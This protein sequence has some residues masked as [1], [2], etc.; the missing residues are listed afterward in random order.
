MFAFEQYLMHKL[1]HYRFTGLSV[2][3]ENLDPA[4]SWKLLI[5]LIAGMMAIMHITSIIF[6][7][8]KPGFYG[9][10]LTKNMVNLILICLLICS[11]LSNMC[12]ILMPTTI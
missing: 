9:Y 5:K 2:R 8:I 12:A 1:D 3:P 6:C 10:K 11:M 7:G 4:I